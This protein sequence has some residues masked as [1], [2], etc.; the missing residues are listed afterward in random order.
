MSFIKSKITPFLKRIKKFRVLSIFKK[1]KKIL[2]N[3][4]D[5]DKKLIYS[6]APRKIPNSKQLKHLNKFLSKKELNILKI[7]F[8]VLLASLSYLIFSYFNNN[9]ETLPKEGGVYTEGVVGYPKN[10]NPLYASENSVDKDLSFLMYSSILKYNNNGELEG[11]LVENYEISDDGKIYSFKIKNNVLWHDNTVLST[12][13]IVFTFNLIKNPEYRSYLRQAF[14]D[15]EIEKIDEL[16]F[17]FI[18]PE[19]YAPFLSLLTFGILPQDLWEGYNSDSIILSDLNLKPIG[20]GPFK[21]KTLYKNKNGEIKEY[22]LEVNDNYYGKKPYLNGINFEFFIEKQEAISALNNRQILGISYLPF[23]AKENLLAQKSLLIHDLIQPQTVALFFNVDNNDFLNDKENRV[24]LEKSINKEEIVSEVF[25][26]SS[27]VS[28]SIY[29]EESLVFNSEIEY[30]SYSKE[31]AKDYFSSLLSDLENKEDD[32]DNE[33]NT[34]ID[35]IDEENKIN[36]ELTIVD[37]EVNGQIANEIK[38]YWEEVGVNLNIKTV[39]GEQAA[40]LITNRSFEILLYGQEIGGDPDIFSFWHSSQR[41]NNGL[42]IAGYNNAQVDKL[43]TEARV[44]VIEKERLDKYKE[45]Q[46]ILN[47]EVPAIFLYSPSYI[48]TQNR[49]LKGFS[50]N[51]LINPENRFN[52]VSDWYLKTKIKLSR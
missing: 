28:K 34:I 29:L 31:S 44:E 45:I 20:S 35:N 42:N 38:K 1:N 52:S 14:L 50:G 12:D 47:V 7:L 39:S 9:L 27:R 8:L 21:F 30:N 5:L 18:L 49:D 51:I 22:Q 17:K 16:S 24:W 23:Q 11:D 19:A 26:N 36:L 15:I 25:N 3:Q 43:L 13:D 48:Y 46:E 6:L 4:L 37:N 41:D 32:E 2:N 40:N 10:I 33:D